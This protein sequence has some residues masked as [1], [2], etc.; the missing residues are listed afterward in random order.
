MTLFFT[1]FCSCESNSFITKVLATHKYLGNLTGTADD[2]DN[3]AW[4]ASTHYSLIDFSKR[5][6]EL[7][8]LNTEIHVLSE[9]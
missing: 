1:S 9:E 5:E 4:M 7:L 8:P 6:I 2:N 3:C